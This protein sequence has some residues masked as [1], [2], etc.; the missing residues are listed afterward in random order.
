MPQKRPPPTQAASIPLPIIPDD[1]VDTD[2]TGITK[3]V[4]EALTAFYRGDSRRLERLSRAFSERI[5]SV[6]PMSFAHGLYWLLG[7]VVRR[8]LSPLAPSDAI[9]AAACDSLVQAFEPE[10]IE[11]IAAG[12][13]AIIMSRNPRSL[14]FF[15]RALSQ[16]IAL[17]EDLPESRAFDRGLLVA[18]RD[19]LVLMF[20]QRR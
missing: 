4:A 6:P 7:V 13:L 5:S 11:T 14:A 1:W 16:S 10:Q 2:P 8:A 9:V 20:E 19:L 3:G 18:C 17:E 15:M 12:M